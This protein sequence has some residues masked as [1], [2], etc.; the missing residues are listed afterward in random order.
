[1]LARAFT[2]RSVTKS[3]LGGGEEERPLRSLPTSPHPAR[4]EE[5]F[6]YLGLQESFPPPG[7]ARPPSPSS[8]PSLLGAIL[9]SP[10]GSTFP[11]PFPLPPPPSF[12]PP[13]FLEPAFP[14]PS[15]TR[16]WGR[17][18]EALCPLRG[19]ARL[20]RPPG[21]EGRCAWRPCPS[22]GDP[23]SP[24]ARARRGGHGGEE[25]RRSQSQGG[26]FSLYK[27]EAENH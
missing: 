11:P 19:R 5:Q 12:P 13:T 16:P 17:E 27:Q 8:L 14:L 6:V 23:R 1:M 20:G 7:S 2:G 26:R 10:A 25:E 3:L 9:P 21:W 18:R 4:E 22:P 15:G 24:R